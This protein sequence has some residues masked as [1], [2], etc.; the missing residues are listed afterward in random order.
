MERVG[1]DLKIAGQ[2]PTLPCPSARMCLGASQFDRP[3]ALRNM[4]VSTSHL[5]AG[6]LAGAIREFGK[7]GRGVRYKGC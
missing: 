1:F 4:H 5:S 3:Q 6:A 7:V 2:I